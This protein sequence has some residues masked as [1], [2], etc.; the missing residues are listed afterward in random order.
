MSSSPLLS[1]YEDEWL[2]AVN[3]PAGHL[4]H[5]SD[6]PQPK[7]LVTLKLVRDMVGQFVYAAHRLDRPT[8]GV[9]LFAK[10][11]TTARALGRAFD[12]Q[13]VRKTYY[14]IVT[15]HPS[16]DQWAC[17]E[18]LQKEPGAPWQEAHTQFHLRRR[19][20]RNLALL[21]ISP[22]TGRYHQIRKHLL[23][24]GHPLVGDFRYAGKEFCH[25]QSE[26]LGTETRML[27]QCRQLALRHPIT[28]ADLLIEAPDEECFV[29]LCTPEI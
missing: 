23:A 29:R 21:E 15:G 7:D 19:L 1:L 11:R 14:G 27:L 25:A 26:H 2:I 22:H 20:D 10:G 5:P 3:K 17:T 12:R 16:S 4:V 6:H 18:P 13:Q 28:H 8:C 9:V 24:C